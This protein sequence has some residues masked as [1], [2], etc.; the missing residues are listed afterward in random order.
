MVDGQAGGKHRGHRIRELRGS[1]EDIDL[2]QDRQLQKKLPLDEPSLFRAEV[3]L[4]ADHQGDDHDDHKDVPFLEEMGD[5][6]QDLRDHRQFPAQVCKCGRQGRHNFG[7]DD[8]DDD[9][10]DNHDEDRVAHD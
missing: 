2:A 4:H 6:D 7:H 5:I 3:N 1:G 8:D 9:D 10:S